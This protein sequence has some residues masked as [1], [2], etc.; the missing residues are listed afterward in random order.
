MK[1]VKLYLFV[2]LGYLLCAAIG[3]GAAFQVVVY[4]VENLF[5]LDGVAQY[6]DYAP[7]EA[8]GQTPRWT[9]ERL[10][11]KL[12]LTAKL[13]AH[14]LKHNGNS[15]EIICFQELE[16]DHTPQHTVDDYTSF[17]EQHKD[18]PLLNLLAAA[19]TDEKLQ[20]LPTE[21]LL[22]KAIIECGGPSYYIAKPPLEPAA[23]DKP[24]HMN[25]VFSVFPI[26][27]TIAH[28][29]EDARD[30]LEVHLTLPSG[31]NLIIFNNHWKSG[32]SNPAFEATRRQNAGVLR[33]R[34]DKIRAQEPDAA[35]LLAGDFNSHYDQRQL[36]GEKT[37]TALNDVLGSGGNK[38]SLKDSSSKSLYNLWYDL[39]P[40]QRGSDIFR[41]N[42]G[43]L[44]QMIITPGLVDK[45]GVDYADGSFRS[46]PIAGLNAEKRWLTPIGW[47][48]YG[49]GHG[50]SDHLPI[51]A[52]F[53]YGDADSVTSR[54]PQLPLVATL[55]DEGR[56]TIDYPQ[57]RKT[58]VHSIRELRNFDAHTLAQN[59]GELYFINT[60]LENSER[61][62][63]KIGKRLFE[64]Y[65]GH[66]EVAEWLRSLKPKQRI[67]IYGMLDEYKGQLQFTIHHPEWIIK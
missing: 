36:L 54:P 44:M 22:L 42:W 28:P 3:S 11:T 61:P 62:T 41:G 6:E 63:L 60:R 65:G 66:P 30:I 12:K 15:P 57:F 48:F 64:L 51:S 31:D 37:V 53:T 35:I 7:F 18:T 5:D 21:A 45:K 34:L 59:F 58:Q 8:D 20:S 52:L 40:E 33:S 25:V 29:V 26:A 17:L 38:G 19:E 24:P 4:N 16:R 39:P 43:T 47:H 50:Y 46:H 23:S 32:A 13:L 55:N 27:K 56:L 9:A 2:A 10:H 49:K 67:R 1:A 14:H